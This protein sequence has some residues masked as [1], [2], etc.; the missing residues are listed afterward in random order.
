MRY[1]GKNDLN[2]ELFAQ[3]LDSRVVAVRAPSG[4]L[5]HILNGTSVSQQ[6]ARNVYAWRR[7]GRNPSLWRADR[8]LIDY[9]LHLNDFFSWCE[10]QGESPWARGKPP[11]WHEKEFKAPK[12]WWEKREAA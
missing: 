11:A 6:D 4:A 9:G 1:I 5:V 12:S 3:F 8:F 7:E 2:G 10:R